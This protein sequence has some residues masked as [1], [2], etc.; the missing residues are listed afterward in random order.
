MLWTRGIIRS[1]YLHCFIFV[2]LNYYLIVITVS[3]YSCGCQSGYNILFVFNMHYLNVGLSQWYILLYVVLPWRQ[4][5]G[6]HRI[7]TKFLVFVAFLLNII[8][9]IF[10][11][12]SNK[13]IL[14]YFNLCLYFPLL[15]GGMWY[16][17]RFYSIFI[18]TP[19]RVF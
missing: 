1:F 7:S 18:W 8:T 19:Y 17:N 2:K 3:V 12:C 15:C 5:L 11:V 10:S 16:I 4:F 6:S 14:W 9:F 13:W